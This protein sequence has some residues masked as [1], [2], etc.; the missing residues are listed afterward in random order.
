MTAREHEDRRPAQWFDRSWDGRVSRTGASD[1]EAEERDKIA[2][3]A[4]DGRWTELF[5]LLEPHGTL[6]NR[7]RLGGTR[8]FAPLHQVAWHGAP[9]D[10][11][12]RLIT[13]GAWRTLRTA[14]G[15]TPL[16]I[17]RDRG[18]T[19]LLDILRPVV[20]HPL[21]EDVLR[22]LEEH[23]T[24]LIRGGRYADF[25]LRQQLRLPQL[26]P[27]TELAVPKLWFP[28]PG[29]YGGIEIELQGTELMVT[30]FSRAGGWSLR[31]RV[32]SS[33]VHFVEERI[34][35]PGV[36]PIV[37]SPEPGR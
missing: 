28:V 7:T 6:V 25:V 3:A 27:I 12:R 26:A 17:A 8:G 36:P 21:P 16:D 18:H 33:S 34:D 5:G 23:L 4:R 10:T 31:Y 19:H 13:L 9:V 29:Q 11:A 1:S 22:G 35:A 32:T 15:K 24:M 14:A 37:R 30:N 20:R 2:D